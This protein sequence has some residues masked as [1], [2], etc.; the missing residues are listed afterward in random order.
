MNISLESPLQPDIERLV[1]ALDAYQI[2]LYPAESHHG[3]ALE[4]LATPAA[5]FAVARNEDGVAVACGA[6]LMEGVF[7]EL[8]RFY[9]VPGHRGRGVARA[10]LSFL[11]GQACSKGCVELALETGIQQ[12]EALA[13]YARSGYAECGPFGDYIA[14]PNSVF[15]KKQLA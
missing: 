11:E 13:F 4:A 1:Q 6:I 2:P 5:L 7:G 12:P 3:V 10:L 8:K 9:T 14:D 15:M